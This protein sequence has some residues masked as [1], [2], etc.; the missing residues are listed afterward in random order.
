MW[1]SDIRWA[2]GQLEDR[3][4]T[5][6]QDDAV[7]HFRRLLARNDLIGQLVAA[8][9][10]SPAAGR[11]IYFSRFNRDIGD[12]RIHPDAP[13][14]LD[15]MEDGTDQATLRR[16]HAATNWD[17]DTRPFSDCLKAWGQSHGY[18]RQQQ[19]DELR[20]PLTTLHGWHAGRSA[21]LEAALR[22]LMTLL[23]HKS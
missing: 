19:A 12:G 5:E 17:T 9:L 11:A 18:S 15:L 13:L 10:V 7:A 2:N 21:A 1:K 4:L 22:L 14:D 20:V 6:N 8:R 16:P 3:L 23:D